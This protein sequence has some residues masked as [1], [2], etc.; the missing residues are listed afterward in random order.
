MSISDFE[1]TEDEFERMLRMA[2]E[3]NEPAVIE[4]VE[5][6]VAHKRAHFAFLTGTGTNEDFDRVHQRRVAA[7]QALTQE[8]R[9]MQFLQ[10]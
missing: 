5:A 4:W 8:Q 7:H 6:T 10:E 3:T 9:Q 1:T 2:H